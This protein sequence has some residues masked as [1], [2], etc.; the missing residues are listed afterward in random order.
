MVMTYSMHG[1]VRNS[2]YTSVRKREGQRSRGRPICSC[3][4]NIKMYLE[5]NCEVVDCI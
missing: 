4:D 5:I 1:D 3:E 2:Y